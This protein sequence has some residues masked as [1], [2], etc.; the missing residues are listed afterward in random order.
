MINSFNYFDNIDNNKKAEINLRPKVFTFL[1]NIAKI[2]EI[3]IFTASQSC[4]ANEVIDY[5]D[6]TKELISHR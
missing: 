5:L 3:A 1:Q 6:P 4:Y 2:Y